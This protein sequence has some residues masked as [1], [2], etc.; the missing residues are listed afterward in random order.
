MKLLSINCWHVHKHGARNVTSKENIL[1][2]LNPDIGN[3]NLYKPDLGVREKHA[4]KFKLTVLEGIKEV[5]LQ[6]L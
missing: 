5:F 3:P 1:T 4:Q 6:V 2:F